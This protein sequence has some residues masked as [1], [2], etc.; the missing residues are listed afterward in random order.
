MT[1]IIGILGLT[2]VAGFYLVSKKRYN[3]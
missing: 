2:A 1:L 3:N